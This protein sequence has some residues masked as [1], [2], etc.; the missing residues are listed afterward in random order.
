M[1]REYYQISDAKNLVETNRILDSISRRLGDAA[2]VISLLNSTE[3]EVTVTEDSPG[4]LTL[5]LPGTIK[6]K[7]SNASRLLATDANK[8]TTSAELVDWIASASGDLSIISDGRGG[9]IISFDSSFPILRR[10]ASVTA[11]L[12]NG[13]RKSDIYTVPTGKSLIVTHCIVRN[14]TASLAGATAINFGTGTT[15]DNWVTSVDL[16]TLTDSTDYAVIDGNLILRTFF[17]LTGKY[18]IFSAGSVFGVKPSVGATADAD[19]TIDLF[20][21]IY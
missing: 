15:V 1:P 2:L 14:P 3:N 18:T 5:S 8:L 6:V 10:L 7:D 20:G 12:Q 16:S 9:V 13:D 4:Q 19:A 17:G 21:Y 11:N